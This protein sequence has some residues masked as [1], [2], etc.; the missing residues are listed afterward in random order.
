[1]PISLGTVS[2][3]N[4]RSDIEKFVKLNKNNTSTNA[5]DITAI[6]TSIALLNAVKQNNLEGCLIGYFKGTD[7]GYFEIINQ[8]LGRTTGNNYAMLQ[9]TNG[10][11]YINAS[12]DQI[13]T[14]RVNNVSKVEIHNNLYT[15]SIL[16]KYNSVAYGSTLTWNFGGMV[17]KVLGN[18]W[19]T[20]LTTI[21]SD[22]RIKKEIEDLDD[23]YCLDIINKIEPKRY[24]YINPLEKGTDEFVI[25][26]IA[27]QVYEHIPYAVNKNNIN[28]L[29]SHYGLCESSGSNIK[30]EK[31]HAFIVGDNVKFIDEKDGELFHNI[32]AIIDDCN[33]T[34]DAILETQQLL[35]IGKKVY[36]FNTLDKNAI[37]TYNVSATQELYRMIIKQQTIID[38]L[39][40]RIEAIE[41]N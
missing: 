22:S 38:S 24:R 10:T 31:T 41:S 15:G 39:L 20:G 2:G 12:S 9:S 13:I 19:I 4:G 37:F 34:I 16:Q 11:T 18:Q 14:L 33:F 29:P 35:C 28:H 40:A 27:Q 32:T 6:N 17:M 5:I 23:K 1:M 7:T 26:F 8:N 3:F 30:T 25:G 36:D 21:S